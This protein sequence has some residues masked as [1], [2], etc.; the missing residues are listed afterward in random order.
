MRQFRSVWFVRELRDFVAL[1]VSILR[2]VEVRFI[3]AKFNFGKGH[4][5]NASC[6]G[7][8]SPHPRLRQ[9][10]RDGCASGKDDSS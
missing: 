4:A 1:R 7:A 3:P 8:G 10:A 5:A 9:R 2:Q 6:A